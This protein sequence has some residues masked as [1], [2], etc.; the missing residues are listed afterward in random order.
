MKRQ[1]NPDDPAYRDRSTRRRLEEKKSK[2]PGQQLEKEGDYLDTGELDQEGKPLLSEEIDVESLTNQ[3]KQKE[4]AKK[5]K[6]FDDAV[7]GAKSKEDLIEAGRI[8]KDIEERLGNNWVSLST[9]ALE[10]FIGIG[11]D[12][13]LASP[14]PISRGLNYGI[15]YGTNIL[16]Q[17]LRGEEI[18][19]GRAHAAGA[20]QAIPFGTAAKGIKGIARATGKGAVGSVVGEQVAV[21]IDEKRV[22]TPEE[23]AYAGAFGGT[24]GGISKSALDNVDITGLRNTLNRLSK[25]RQVVQNLDGTLSI[26]DDGIDLAKQSAQPMRMAGAQVN[27]A[28]AAPKISTNERLKQS[29]IANE[30]IELPPAYKG[31]PVTFRPEADFFDVSAALIGGGQEDARDALGRKI[32][33]NR[34]KVTEFGATKSERRDMVFNHIKNSLRRNKKDGTGTNITRREF[35]EYAKEQIAGEKDLRKAIKLLNIRS[36]ASL[37]NIDLSDY[38][39]SEAQLELLNQINKAKVKPRRSKT[40]TT[41]QFQNKV[42]KWQRDTAPYQQFTDYKETFDYGHI[43]SA[44]TGFRAEDLGMN[45]ISNTEIEAA[46]NVASID[47]YTRKIIEILQE[48]NRE[49]GSRR[50]Y[51]PVVQRMR[52]T[53]GSVVEDFVKWKA[54]KDNDPVNLTK[55]LDKFI[56]RDQHDNY[57]QFIQKKF[58]QKRALGYAT[59][60]EFV[61]EVYGFDYKI[62][63]D[64]PQ[65]FKNKVEKEYLKQRVE[66]GN[67]TGKQQYD[68]AGEWMLEAID[69]FIGLHHLSKPKRLRTVKEDTQLQ[70]LDDLPKDIDDLMDMILPDRLPNE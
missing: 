46:H 58:Y 64:M 19:Q 50:D 32:D 28:K 34:A 59:I 39:T 23:V 6:K 61:E 21:G 51:L 69:E 33:Y 56:P 11:A 63:K 1:P 45:R 41:E 7:A 40:D 36:Y 42:R 44:K 14:D 60:K 57:L 38:P 35:N 27:R 49:R 53:A 47:P 10:T 52:N 2:T 24:F 20:F 15:G 31:G 66:S 54:N 22:L 67:I 65:K 70:D 8:R 3:Q 43:I 18:K 30:V 26:A 55:I 48:G 13:L 25:K 29:L 68:Q 17:W 12:V 16:A 62:F 37:K 5:W 4:D 9:L